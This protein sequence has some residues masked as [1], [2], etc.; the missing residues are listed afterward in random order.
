MERR[1]AA[2]LVADM[3]GYSRL[4]GQDEA[5]T[6]QRLKA[7]R[8]EL[9]DP[10]IAQHG[11][12]AI[13]W[14]GDGVLVE[15]N[16]IVQ[17]V[18][19]AID[20]QR[21]MAE[22]NT[23]RPEDECI[24]FRMGLN[25]GDIVIEEDNLYGDGINV[26]ARL[27]PLAPPGGILV[28]EEVARH[29]EGKISNGLRFVG[30]RTLKNI[31]RPVRVYRVLLT[32][33]DSAQQSHSAP[34]QRHYWIGAALAVVIISIAVLGMVFAPGFLRHETALSNAPATPSLIVL[35]FRNLSDDKTQDYFVDGMTE[36]LITDL[37]RLDRLF[38]IA[39]NT[40]FA[41]RDRS[42][43]ASELAEELNIR[44]VLE[45]SVRRQGEQIRVSAQ[46]IDAA[47]D[48]QLWGERYDRQLTD[49]FAVQDDLKQE[50]VTALSVRLGAGEQTALSR[51]PTENVEA[52]EFYLR[53]RHTRN[54]G[55]L[56]S[57]RLAYWALEKAI[58]L[59]P[60]FAKALAL[61]ADIYALDYTGINTSLDWERSPLITKSAAEQ[62]ARHA[63][64]VDPS[65]A[66]PDIALAR[67][68][69]AELRF[70]DALIHAQRAVELE[71]GLSDSHVIL[72][73]ALSALGRHQEA[74]TAVAEAFRLNPK[75]PPDQHA[76]Q[77]MALFGLGDYAAAYESFKAAAAT[78]AV[79][80]NWQDTVLGVAAA[81][82]AGTTWSR[83]ATTAFAYIQSILA[84]P[85]FATAEDQMRLIEGIRL[86][87]EPEY[88]G[89]IVSQ[90]VHALDDTA[91]KAL[92]FGR[93]A[94]SFCHIT[95]YSP[96]LR[97]S[98]QGQTLWKLRYDI[99]EAGQ[100]QVEDG[101]LCLR[102]PVISRG[103]DLCFRIYPN[104]PPA[105]FSKDH[106]YVMDGP[107]LCFF[108][109]LN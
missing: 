22:R 102:F 108:T 103:R 39:R 24:V 25:V 37:S 46:L 16:S 55:E 98:K 29:V 91:I 62:F 68:R 82:F 15:F 21:G 65:I 64:A 11:G 3:V 26:A 81:G 87:G 86:A 83:R 28:S 93:E 1:L 36:D 2:L 44:Y 101:R 85:I 94:T 31:E 92:L 67:L 77:G 42:A 75:A 66:T 63:Q 33:S 59:E 51:P 76:V 18:Q 104:D 41:Y 6:V 10:T 109:P 74:L 47:T 80:L 60:D 8:A 90:S 99:S 4:I 56:R 96:S 34:R 35:P 20:I 79:S 84:L 73:R 100:A 105:P 54:Q 48:R 27:E 19:C 45:G 57:I 40:A 89:D 23:A 107:L 5:G 69:L 78:A 52:Y 43:T 17:A 49:V 50:I 32:D 9:I 61:L 95:K 58:E 13:H 12:T 53:A 14:A 30:E 7:D 72:A 71:P 70:Q 88:I 97:I 106:S 38:V